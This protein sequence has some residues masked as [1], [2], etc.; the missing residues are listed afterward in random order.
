MVPNHPSRGRTTDLNC[1]SRWTI[2]YSGTS[3]SDWNGHPPGD[4][5]FNEPY[6]IIADTRFFVMWLDNPELMQVIR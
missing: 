4:F 5:R 3:G 6:L 2:L 1:R